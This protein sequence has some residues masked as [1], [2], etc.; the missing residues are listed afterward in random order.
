MTFSRKNAGGWVTDDPIT[1]VQINGID[2]DTSNAV[3]GALGGTYTPSSA[4]SIAG[5]AGLKFTG[6]GNAAWPQTISQTVTREHHL[7]ICNISTAGSASVDPVAW[8]VQDSAGAP[9]CVQTKQIT[10]VGDA[11]WLE[12]KPLDGS[13]L[14]S[15]ILQTKGTTGTTIVQA[16]YEIVRWTGTTAYNSMVSPVSDDHGNG[17]FTTTRTQTITPTS[18][19]T[20]DLATYKYALKVVHPYDVGAGAA[21]KVLSIKANYLTS[22]IRYS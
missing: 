18:G 10:A 9:P 3:D 7:R 16:T 15:V 12:L 20:I 17:N 2:T 8:L 1:A 22:T 4:I 6:T 5:T 13:T 21:M 14:V 19:T 11:H